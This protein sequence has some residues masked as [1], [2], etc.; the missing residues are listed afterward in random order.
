M[1]GLIPTTPPHSLD[2]SLGLMVGPDPGKESGSRRCNE[3]RE[4][5]ALLHSD[6]CTGDGGLQSW[7]P[8]GLPEP[9]Q[10]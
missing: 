3:H 9:S 10:Y 4:A 8:S 7:S 5:D 2:S 1:R 6:E